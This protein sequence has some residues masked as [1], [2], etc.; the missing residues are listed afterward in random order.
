MNGYPLYP[1]GYV[2]SPFKEPVPPETFHGVDSRIELKSEFEEAL[3]GLEE[4]E[5]LLVLFRFHLC[6]GF[7]MK[8]HPRGDARNPLRGVFS[9]CSPNRPN[10]IGASHVR[11][12]EI[13]GPVLV[14][15]GLDAVDGTPVIDIKPSRRIN[16]E[17]AGHEASPERQ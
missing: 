10:H 4:G 16:W 12:K 1:V 17:R 5:T 2:R 6:R 7:P 15:E 13:R 3:E 11:L 8:V 9:T 14:V